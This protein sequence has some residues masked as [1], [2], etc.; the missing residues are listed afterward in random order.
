MTTDE[1]FN[2]FNETLRET[3]ILWTKPSELSF[4][5][6]LGIPIII[7]PTI[8]SLEDFNKKRCIHH[9]FYHN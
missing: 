5:A 3:D 7:A 4:Y 1:Y 9:T 2:T 6:G 8:G